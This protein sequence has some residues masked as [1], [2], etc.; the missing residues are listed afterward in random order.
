MLKRHAIAAVLATVLFCTTFPS[1]AVAGP[2]QVGDFVTHSQ[3][4]W[5]S[6]GSAAEQ[7]LLD[8]FF[9][10]YPNGVEVG[11]PGLAGNSM[12]FNTVESVRD[13]LPQAGTPGPLNND[14]QDPSSTS[15]GVLGGYVLGMTLNVDFNDAGF[16]SGTV[17][18]RFGDLSI[19]NLGTRMVEGVLEDFSGLNG[20]SVRQ[21]LTV[22]DTCLGGGICLQTYD[23]IG[24][25][26]LDLLYAFDGGTPSPFAQAH[27]QLPAGP[28]PPPV[29]EPGT[30]TLLA[31]GL[32][33]Y[34]GRVFR[35]GRPS[36]RGPG[37]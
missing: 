7:L 12:I 32:T 33:S 9:V 31:L 27:L 36:V 1:A 17:A 6:I 5:G 22:A 30:L 19:S 35:P 24:A 10:V 3:D 13:Y 18:T 37:L 28:P 4:S 2:F 8:H 14:L 15:A 23:G 11:L 16:L 25:I 21:F 34:V 20:L 26:A 29:P